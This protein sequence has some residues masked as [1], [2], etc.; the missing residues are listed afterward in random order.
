MTKSMASGTLHLH[1]QPVSTLCFPGAC[2]QVPYSLCASVSSPGREETLAAR[3]TS[4]GDGA[5]L[6]VNTVSGETR[7]G[8]REGR[9]SLAFLFPALLCASVAKFPASVQG[10][11]DQ[12]LP[13]SPASPL[14][15]SPHLSEPQGAPHWRHH[16]LSSRHRPLGSWCLPPSQQWGT[17]FSSFFISST[18]AWDSGVTCSKTSSC[19]PSLGLYL[20]LPNPSPLHYLLGQGLAYRYFI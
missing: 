19:S 14:T 1:P 11:H 10:R 15:S 8:P 3:P 9:L 12:N 5:W 7:T 4:F 20:P 16:V 6:L 13:S 17:P 18:P 2:R